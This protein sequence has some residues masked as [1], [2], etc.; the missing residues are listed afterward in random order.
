MLPA[1]HRLEC[2]TDPSGLQRAARSCQVDGFL[3]VPNRSA[4][5]GHHRR[6]PF[7]LTSV[8][9]ARRSAEFL[10]SGHGFPAQGHR[11]TCDACLAEPFKVGFSSIERVNKLAQRQHDGISILHAHRQVMD[12]CPGKSTPVTLGRPRPGCAS[13][14]WTGYWCFDVPKRQ[15][16]PGPISSRF[17]RIPKVRQR[18]TCNGKNLYRAQ[19][20]R[21][22]QKPLFKC[23][24][25]ACDAGRFL[26]GC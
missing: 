12:C 13:R 6:R 5:V 11:L 26:S 1:R 9:I 15:R 4:V 17:P 22:A 3:V 23:V 7:G 21:C 25:R 18:P 8:A 10:N 16:P 19:R 20:I 24:H 2:W 14:P